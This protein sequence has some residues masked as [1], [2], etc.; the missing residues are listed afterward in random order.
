MIISDAQRDK[1]K[2]LFDIIYLE[3]EQATEL[4]MMIIEC[5]H[6]WDD[7]IDQDK[8][9][10]KSDANKA[11]HNAM[12]KLPVHKLYQAMPQ[13]PYLIQDVYFKWVA[14]NEFESNGENLEKAYVLRAE[15]YGIFV[16]IACFLHG[17]AHA[18]NITALVW[19]WYG[20][21]LEDFKEEV[22]QCQIQ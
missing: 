21:N 22:R 17:Q 14:A 16:H 5:L 7:C 2:E 13:M 8:P 3:N 6:V 15:L 4:S 12:I 20:E 11:W 9:I 10:D 18:E 1:F 19:R